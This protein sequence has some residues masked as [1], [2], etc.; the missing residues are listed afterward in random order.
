[1]TPPDPEPRL[2]E[3]SWAHA[4]QA[5][6][7]SDLPSEKRSHWTCSLRRIAKALDRP[8]ETLPARWTSVRPPMS[9]LHSARVGLTPKTLSNHKANV[10]AALAWLSAEHDLPVRGTPLLPFWAALWDGISDKGLR[11]RLYGLMRF[12]SA[13]QLAPDHINDEVIAAYLSYRATASNLA[14]GIAAHRS[15]AR[16]WNRCANEV[17]GWPQHQ[18]T[19]PAL[20]LSAAGADW[21]DLSE[22]LRQD[23]QSYLGSLTK[24]RRDVRGR[25]FPPVKAST[26]RTR[27]AEL[28]AF[29]RKASSIGF[30]LSQFTSLG[31]L[32][33]PDVV[34]AVLEAYW[35]ESGAEPSTYTIDLAWKLHAI[36]RDTGCLDKAALES[37]DNLQAELSHYRRTGLT[38]KNLALVRQVLSGSIWAEVVALP[39]TLMSE[40]GTLDLHASVK[41]ALRAQLAVAIAILTVAPVRLS[42]LVRICLDENLIPPAGPSEPHWLVFPEYDVKNRVRL[43]FPLDSG[44]S[45]LIDEYVHYH[46]PILLRGSNASWLFPGENGDHKTPSM[47][48]EQITVA[49]QKAVGIRLTTHQFRHAAAAIILRHDPGN[50]EWARRVLGHKN[51]QTTINFYIGLETTDAT[52]RFGQIIRPHVAVGHARE[53]A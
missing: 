21:Q 2:L 23:L 51:I 14:S 44:V 9:R 33:A 29:I 40:A 11:A 50:Y 10:K 30:P 48:S 43:E 45:G 25:R 27:K 5:I 13:Q 49:V 53:R 15:I 32:L 38:Q 41:A 42:N 4:V 52:R 34:E 47:F 17:E 12:A 18:L 35:K 8:L 20:P 7:A 46:R 26:L 37:L 16:S 3:M 28:I 24:P 31:A 6:D 1:M 36:A 39:N 19:E 22:G